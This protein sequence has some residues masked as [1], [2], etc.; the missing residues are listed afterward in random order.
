ML[1]HAMSSMGQRKED[2]SPVMITNGCSVGVRGPL[3][4]LSHG[5]SRHGASCEPIRLL[6]SPLPHIR[7][8]VYF[9]WINLYFH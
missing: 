8:P 9:L 6:V 2:V 4:A 5:A 3:R 1:S 7:L